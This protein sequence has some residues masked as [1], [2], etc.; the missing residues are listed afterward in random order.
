MPIRFSVPQGD[1]QTLHVIRNVVLEAR[2]TRPPH[3][4]M[5]TFR[6][7]WRDA[8]I[9]QLYH[10]ADGAI[11]F[12]MVPDGFSHEIVINGR[13]YRL[14]TVHPR[15]ALPHVPLRARMK[16]NAHGWLKSAANQASLFVERTDP[17]T[18]EMPIPLSFDYDGELFVGW[19]D[20]IDLGGVGWGLER[21][22]L[23]KDLHL[24]LVDEPVA[25]APEEV[26]PPLAEP[27]PDE[28][29]PDLVV[30]RLKRG[31]TND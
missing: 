24:G 15:T 7:E 6:R 13:Y 3:L 18:P 8:A 11:D 14:M 26:V 12:V 21:A 2:P 27:A 9:R 31:T 20:N 5:H 19:P 25:P 30:P 29:V 22:C 1:V 16:S 4:P 28:A 17:G 10:F 23:V